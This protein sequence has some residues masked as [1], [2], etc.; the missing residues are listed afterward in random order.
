VRNAARRALV[1]RCGIDRSA[2]PGLRKRRATYDP[3][4]HR[5]V[6]DRLG[7]ADRHIYEYE[8]KQRGKAA[9]T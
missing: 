6:A 5:A 1:E 7:S 8:D 2:P 9:G 3:A 4:R